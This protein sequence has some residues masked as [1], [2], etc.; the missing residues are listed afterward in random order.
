MATNNGLVIAIDFDGTIVTHEYPEIGRDLGAIPV[1][2]ELQGRGY[3]LILHTM[4]SGSLLKR[5]VAW[6]EERGLKFYAVNTNP[7][8]KSWTDSPKLYA[9]L[10]I[11][12]SALG[13][14]IKFID[15]VKRPAVNWEKV[16]EQLIYDG[17]L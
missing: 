5:A 12:D 1:L 10:Y 11:D 16:R 17:L 4:R 7:D 8:Q 6:C 2:K 15:G 14:P 13:C 9:D 3:R